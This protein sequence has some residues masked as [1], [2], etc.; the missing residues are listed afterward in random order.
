MKKAWIIFLLE[1]FRLSVFGQINLIKNP[2]FESF[3]TCPDNLSQ[4]DRA[5]YWYTARPTPDTLTPA[6]P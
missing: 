3:D 1:M 5:L 2:S 4:I 6:L